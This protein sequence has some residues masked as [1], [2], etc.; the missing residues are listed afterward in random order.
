MVVTTVSHKFA[1]RV[2]R[3]HP[4]KGEREIIPV[5]GLVEKSIFCDV[6]QSAKTQIHRRSLHIYKPMDLFLVG[7][8]R[9]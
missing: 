3:G 1:C 8:R 7:A 2:G 9:T 6:F 4:F 5:K